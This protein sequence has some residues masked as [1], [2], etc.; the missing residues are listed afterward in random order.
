MS[1]I[2]IIQTDLYDLSLIYQSPCTSPCGPW[3][4]MEL[5]LPFTF[6]CR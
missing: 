6:I 1:I 4:T 3:G 2:N 5:P